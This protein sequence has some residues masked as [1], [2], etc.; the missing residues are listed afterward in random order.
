MSDHDVFEYEYDNEDLE[1]E[2]AARKEEEQNLAA[3]LDLTLFFKEKDLRQ[4]TIPR[5]TWVGIANATTERF[6]L[7]AFSEEMKE[8]NTEGERVNMFLVPVQSEPP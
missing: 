2:I 6:K 3:R 7:E 1:D 4:N 5:S 8:K